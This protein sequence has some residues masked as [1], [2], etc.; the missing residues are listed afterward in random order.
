MA[1]TK[2]AAVPQVGDEAP[3][4]NLPS[5]QG[6]NLRLSIR[7]VKGPVVVAFFRGLWS[8]EDVEYFKTLAAKEDDINLAIGSVV[9]VCISEPAAA[10]A[11][12]RETKLKSY[13]LYDY[14]KL[15]TPAWGLMEKDPEHG[16]HARPATFLVDLDGKISAAWTD[17]RPSPEELLE[18]VSAITGL[19]KEPEEGEEDEKPARKPRPKKEAAAKTGGGESGEATSDATAEKKPPKEKPPKEKTPE[20]ESQGEEPKA[21]EAKSETPKKKSKPSVESTDEGGETEGDSGGS[22]ETESGEGEGVEGGNVEEK[23]ESGG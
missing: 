14:A 11:F 16:D 22:R 9:G 6:G 1:R 12:V 4:F 23:K 2:N 18:K 7:T 3:D 21:D 5:A 15:A 13:V 17:S 10:R 19:P 8:E 20:S